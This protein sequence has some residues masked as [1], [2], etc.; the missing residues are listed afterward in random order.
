MRGL[1]RG[2]YG[3]VT[4]ECGERGVLG[5]GG[6][7]DDSYVDIVFFQEMVKFYGFVG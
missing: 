2:I 4:I 5:E 3:I 1:G 7:L 6:F